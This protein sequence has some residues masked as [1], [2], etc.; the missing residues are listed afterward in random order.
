MSETSP[1]CGCALDPCIPITKYNKEQLISDKG[2]L[3]PSAVKAHDDMAKIQAE[4]L[5][6]KRKRTRQVLE[7]IEVIKTLLTASAWP[8]TPTHTKA[9]LF[10]DALEGKIKVNADNDVC[11]C[12]RPECIVYS[13][14]QCGCLYCE[15]AYAG[16]EVKS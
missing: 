2:C 4:T 6:L 10:I 11:R 16:L 3:Y 9:Q 8:H 7:A 12:V 1:K 13:K 15:K 5:A 14:G